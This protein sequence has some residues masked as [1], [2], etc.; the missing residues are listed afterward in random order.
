[1]SMIDYE[2]WLGAEGLMRRY[3]MEYLR[4]I[5]SRRLLENLH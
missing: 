3:T 5:D 1:M 2:Y 4:V